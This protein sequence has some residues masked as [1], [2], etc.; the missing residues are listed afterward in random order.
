MIHTRC[1]NFVA[2]FFHILP[3]KK[4]KKHTISLGA[5]TMLKYCKTLTQFWISLAQNVA[6]ITA[7][8]YKPECLINLDM[9]AEEICN[10]DK[11]KVTYHFF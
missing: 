6:H 2:V 11:R 9:R 4:K 1:S 10:E 7:V 3:K 8:I 5:K